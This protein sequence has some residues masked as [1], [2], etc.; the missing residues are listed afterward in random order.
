MFTV[1]FIDIVYLVAVAI[2]EIDS[3]ICAIANNLGVFIAGRAITG[4]GAAGLFP[5]LTLFLHGLLPWRHA[6]DISGCLVHLLVSHPLWVPLWA[7][8]LR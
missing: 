2:S 6:H 7:V 1:L 5:E 3:L 4:V 8:L